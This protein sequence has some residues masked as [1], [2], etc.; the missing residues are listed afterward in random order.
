[1]TRVYYDIKPAAFE[2]VGNGD[3]L[4]H[5]DIREEKVSKDYMDEDAEERTQYSCYEVTIHGKPEY[6]KCVEAVIRCDYTAEAELSLINQYNSYQQGMPIDEKVVN[7]YAQYL[8]Y[9]S[10]VK[11]MVK[12]DLDIEDEGSKSYASIPRLADISKLLSLTINTMDLTDEQ[13]L[14]VKSVYPKW[15]DFIDKELSQGMKVQ[16]EGKLYKVLQAVNPVLSIYPPGAVGTEALY[17]VINESHAG[18]Q[19]DPIPYEQNMVLEKGKYYT[20]YGVVYECIMT[21]LTGYPNDL[22][23][24][25]SIVSPISFN[26]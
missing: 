9:V 3:F 21:T 22:K 7:E 1:M 24:M 6:G 17:A 26:L 15:E 19:E 8:S 18:T 23:D 5:W 2:A 25:P 4:Y 11:T 20:Q 16:H 13:S 10:G 12:K 14:S